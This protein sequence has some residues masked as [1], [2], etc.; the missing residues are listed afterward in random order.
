GQLTTLSFR[1]T[2]AN[3]TALL[4]NGININAPTVGQ[5]DYST[6]PLL[7]FDEMAIQY[8]SAASCVGTDAIGGSILLG[9][10]PRWKQKGFNA[11]VGG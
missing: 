5:T 3:H 9:S 8:G 1:G 10:A 4:W 7:G 2:S 6:V 11:T